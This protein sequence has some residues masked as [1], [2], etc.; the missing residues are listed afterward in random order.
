[1]RAYSLG[2]LADPLRSCLEPR[3]SLAEPVR[4]ER[5]F[6]RERFLSFIFSALAL[7]SACT[8]SLVFFLG[9]SSAGDGQ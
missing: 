8:S 2:V 9:F 4:L 1:M 6:S 7:L 3:M 5:D